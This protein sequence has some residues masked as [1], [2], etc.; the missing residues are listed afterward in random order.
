MQSHVGK[1][2]QAP[3]ASDLFL[4]LH[5]KTGAFGVYLR[6]LRVRNKRPQLSHREH[7]LVRAGVPHLLAKAP[8]PWTCAHSCPVLVGRGRETFL[9]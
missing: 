7:T 4:F 1:T 5:C 2:Q 6:L 3:N 9:S 8:R